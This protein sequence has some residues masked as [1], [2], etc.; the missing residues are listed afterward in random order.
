MPS[1]GRVSPAI[2]HAVRARPANPRGRPPGA[3]V[4]PTPN[5]QPDVNHPAIQLDHLPGALAASA[6]AS[7]WTGDA[8]LVVALVAGLTMW[9]IGRKLVRPLCMLVFAA[10]GAS[11]GFFGP[12]IAGIDLSPNLGLAIGGVLGAVLGIAFFRVSMAVSLGAALAVT[13][14]IAAALALRISPGLAGAAPHEP[15]TAEESFLPDVPVEGVS[16]LAATAEPGA[17]WFATNPFASD[18]EIAAATAAAPKISAEAADR[19]GRFAQELAH[20][21][22]ADWN[23]LPVRHR[24]ILLGAC[25]VGAMGG[26]LFGIARPKQVAAISAAFTGAAAWMPAAVV[27]MKG[28]SVP[29]ESLLPASPMAWLVAWLAVSAIGATL[30]LMSIRGRADKPK[31]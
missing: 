19:V 28:H 4:L 18:E 20:E 24:L 29:G 6:G 16:A 21:A 27:L 23:A 9:L 11:I 2:P 5:T 15:L 30:Q 17:N 31:E 26:F 3:T 1:G 8:A 10:V 14:P 22:A 25:L 7:A 12:R 13:L